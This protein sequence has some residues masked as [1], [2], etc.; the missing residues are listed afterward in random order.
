M[1]SPTQSASTTPAATGEDASKE[2][3]LLLALAAI[4][5]TNIVDF[6]VMMPLGPQ[7]TELF[8]IS[9][10]QFGLLVSAYTLAAGASGVFASAYVDK[11]GR[12]ALMLFMYAG[13]GLATLACALSPSYTTLL[14]ARVVAGVFGGVLSALVQTVVADAVPYARRGQAMGLV[15]ASFSLATVAGVPGSL[16]LAAQWGWHMPF[17]ALALVALPVWWFTLRNLPE[18]TAH[19]QVVKKLTA[20]QAIRAVLA[21]ANHWRA[22]LLALCLMSAGF[23]IIPYITIYLSANLGLTQQQIPLIYLAG[24]VATLMSSRLVGKL[25]DRWGKVP[26]F[27]TVAL[28]ALLP[29]LALTHLPPLP[30]AWVLV[31]TTAFFVLVSG[32]MVPGLS[33]IGAAGQPALRGTFL[34]LNGAVQSGAMGVASWVGGLL[35]ERNAAN[36]VVGYGRAGWVALGLTL[37]AVWLVGQVKTHDVK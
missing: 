13:F 36:Q 29:M 28:L 22:F 15:M 5:F 27:R 14:I 9:D 37:I 30:I 1:T 35:I 20:L 18:L 7:L 11:F 10:A 26:T 3:R 32:R 31:V 17:F 19:L 24:G 21:D 6:M 23:S 25:A 2:R 16:M 4:Q 12:R 33:I 8:R 34:S